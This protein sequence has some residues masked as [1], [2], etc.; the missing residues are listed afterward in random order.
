VLEFRDVVVDC[1]H[2]ASLARFWAAA[3]EGYAIAP[4]DD[5]ELLRLRSAGIDGPEDDPSVVL[6]APLGK[7]RMWFQSVPEAKTVKNRVHFDLTASDLDAEVARLLTLGARRFEPASAEEGLVIMQDP[8]GNEFC[9]I[10]S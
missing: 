4:Y 6:D 3:L 5:E 9:V 2:A 7:P 10:Q 1:R 8:E